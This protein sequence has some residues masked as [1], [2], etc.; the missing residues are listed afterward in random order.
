M[1]FKKSYAI[2]LMVLALALLGLQAVIW[3]RADHNP[4]ESD[5]INRITQH[6]PSEIAGIAGLSLLVLDGLL[7]SIPR[8]AA[9]H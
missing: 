2:A 3:A 1:R 6:P 8:R 7:L 9:R 5:T 4:T